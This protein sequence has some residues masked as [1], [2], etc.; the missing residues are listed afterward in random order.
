MEF[1]D[2]E[3]KS[4]PDKLESIFGVRSIA[5]EFISKMGLLEY[6]KYRGTKS[7]FAKLEQ[8][9]EDICKL[10]SSIFVLLKLFNSF[11]FY[12]RKLQTNLVKT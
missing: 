10:N 11:S 2:P 5:Q 9:F 7:S 6:L 3:T 1:A 8:V 12:E 4:T